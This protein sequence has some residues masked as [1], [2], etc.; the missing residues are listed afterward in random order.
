MSVIT[1]APTNFVILRVIIGTGIHNPHILGAG[2]K[3]ILLATILLCPITVPA[4][5]ATPAEQI[6]RLFS[7]A[8][9]D[10]KFAGNVLVVRNGATVYEKSFGPASKSRQI[11][12][13]SESRF[14]IASVSKPFTA[15]AVLKL[16]EQG[17][18]H[19][20]DRLD[21]IFSELKGAAV[22]GI[23]ISRL[24]SHTSGI[25][26]VVGKHLDRPLVSDDLKTAVFAS[27]AGEF[28]YSNSGYM[29]L[30]LVMEKVTG[31]TYGQLL[32]TFI[33]RPAGMIHSGLLRTGAAPQNLSLSYK[34]AEAETPMVSAIPLEVFDGAGTV[35]STAGDLVK[36]DKALREKRL[37]NGATQAMMNSG[38]TP[39]GNWGYGWARNEQDGKVLLAHQGDYNGYHAVFVRR[40]ESQDLIIILSNLD[41]TNVS[42]LQKQVL[43][44]LR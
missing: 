41:T 10:G 1:G 26:E 43:E 35:F 11:P 21:N 24:L 13:S 42:S 8:A 22:A 18:L 14:S 33:F 19:L 37:L 23:T 4:L 3:A 39:S 27:N 7:T 31:Q 32:D 16:V 17:K 12:N 36:F 40:A 20:E 2:M 28:Q 29:V 5:A 38:H 6:D 15:V 44:I 30:K 9:A 34:T 25:E